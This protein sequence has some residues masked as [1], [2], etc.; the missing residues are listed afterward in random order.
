MFKIIGVLFLI[1]SG[2]SIGMIFSIKSINHINFLK[3]YIYLILMI[4][5]EIKYSQ[6]PILEILKT[7]HHE[8][9]L[10]ECIKKC[11]NL[12]ENNNLDTAWKTAFSNLNNH[13]GIS[14][15]EETIIK[16]FASKLGASDIS[17]QIKYCD[18]NISAMKPHLQQALE[19][20]SKNQKLPIVLGVSISMIISLIFI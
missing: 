13:Y 16:N 7:Y 3:E 1:G 10:A 4:Q 18:Y 2:I 9:C 15:E 11:I 5:T 14:L 17:S 12:S 6:K 19:N 20:K 8:S